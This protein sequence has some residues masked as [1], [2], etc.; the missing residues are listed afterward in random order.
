MHNLLEYPSN[1]TESSESLWQFKR[2]EQYVS[3]AGN[4]D[5]VTTDN[6][7][8]FKYKSGLSK[9]SVADGANTVFKNEKIGIPLKYLS[10]F[11]RSLEML[12][13][14]CKIYSELSWR[15]NT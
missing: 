2:D 12:L 6:S 10:N 14:N 4:P 8:S 15:N 7:S 13:N 5:N 9:E 11:F 3:N 1:Y